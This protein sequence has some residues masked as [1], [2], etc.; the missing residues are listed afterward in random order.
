MLLVPLLITAQLAKTQ[1][2][3]LEEVSALTV[4]IRAILVM[5]LEHVPAVSAD[6]TSSKVP[7]KLLVL[8]ELFLLT[9][10]VD[11]LQVSFRTVNA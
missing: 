2:S 1:L 4:L 10:S 5:Q 6:S 9:E 3:L 8:L 7:A 11:A